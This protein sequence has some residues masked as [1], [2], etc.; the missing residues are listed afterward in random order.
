MEVVTLEGA[1]AGIHSYTN[2]ENCEKLVDYRLVRASDDPLV[3]ETERQALRAWRALDCRDAGRVD[4][5][6]DAAGTPM[7]LEV[8]PLAGLHPTHS[9]LPILCSKLDIP[10]VALIERIVASASERVTNRPR[11]IVRGCA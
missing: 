8:N 4:M 11:R 1:E 5:R 6:C 7:F 10:Y 2:K 3:A 9:D